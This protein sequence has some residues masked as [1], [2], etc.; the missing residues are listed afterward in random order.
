MPGKYFAKK[1]N[2]RSGGGPFLQTSKTY[3]QG[4]N[5]IQMGGPT[6]AGDRDHMLG[7]LRRGRGYEKS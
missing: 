4:K 5:P 1:G 7:S 3:G 2:K 6:G